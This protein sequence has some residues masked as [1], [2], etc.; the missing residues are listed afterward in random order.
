MAFAAPHGGHGGV[1]RE[2]AIRGGSSVARGGPAI[3]HSRGFQ[4]R[5]NQH[6]NGGGNNWRYRHH[7]HGNYYAYYGYPFYPYWGWDYPY[8]YYHPYGYY[9]YGYYNYYY[10]EPAFG[11]NDNGYAGASIVAQLQERLAQAGYYH[12]N[13]DGIVGPLTRRAIRA[14]ERDH[15]MPVDGRLTRQLLEQMD[16][17]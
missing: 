13:V 17:R 16:L 10:S 1:A 12:G 2:G 9:P 3:S 7:Y 14:Y 8:G 15:G 11:G 4:P 5:F 6:W